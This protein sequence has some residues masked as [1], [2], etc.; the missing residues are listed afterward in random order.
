MF[1]ARHSLVVLFMLKTFATVVEHTTRGSEHMSQ[2]NHIYSPGAPRDALGRTMIERC[3]DEIWELKTGLPATE[4]R[5]G[6]ILNS[7]NTNWPTTERM[8]AELER[9]TRRA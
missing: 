4:H 5:T 3:M 6:R 9:D 2:P 1:G 8:D 7:N